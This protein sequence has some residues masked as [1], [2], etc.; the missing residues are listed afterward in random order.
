MT[1]LYDNVFVGLFGKRI[2]VKNATKTTYSEEDLNKLVMNFRNEFQSDQENR[3]YTPFRKEIPQSWMTRM[4]D[5]AFE[6]I[7]DDHLFTFKHLLEIPNPYGVSVQSALLLFNTSKEYRVRYR[8]LGKTEDCDF[9]GETPMTTRH[10]VPIFGLYKGYTNKLILELLDEQG[11]VQQRRDLR[12][13]TRDI[14]LNLQNIV[15]KVEKNE[16]FGFDFVMVNGLRFKPLVYDHNGEVRYSMQLRTGKF[17]M[18]PLENGHFLYED[19]T[20]RRVS[21]GLPF[22]CQYHEI[23]YLGRIYQSYLVDFPISTVLTQ[24]EDS[25]FLVTASGD[26]YKNDRIIEV[27][28]HSGKILS[29]CDMVDI[30]GEKYR[31]R[32]AWVTITGLC[33]VGDTLLITLRRFHTVLAVDWSSKE[34]QWVL[35]P[36][37]IW[38]D[39]PLEQKVLK[40]ADGQS[41]VDGYMP[42]S[43]HIQQ[44]K[45]GNICLSLYCIQDRGNVPAEGAE[46]SDD[47]RIVTYLVNPGKKQFEKKQDIDVVKAKRYASSSCEPEQNRILSFSGFLMRRSQNLRACIEELDGDTGQWINRLRLCKVYR[48]AWIFKPDIGAMSRKMGHDSDVLFGELQPPEVFEGTLPEAVEDR[49]RKK[50]FGNLRVRGDLF[51]CAFKPGSVQKVYLIGEQHSYVQDFSML[52][53]R[54]LKQ[55]FAISLKGLKRDE[56]QIY[57]E[58]GDQIYHLKNEIRVERSQNNK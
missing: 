17:G 8:V 7:L 9:V 30:L 5:M 21:G 24:K 58:Y 51:L 15:T 3:I 33:F 23:D 44:L 42:D 45:D 38:K 56:Y 40:A 2:D 11:Q 53:Q 35:A 49:L 19:T 22:S 37:S 26:K 29:S 20:A 12:I 46:G 57:V 27:D 28:R 34:V 18:V 50:I 16:P 14:P 1:H 31:N 48:G 25:L 39:T 47:S 6:K 52:P 55:S 43:S 4:R 13:Y 41:R 32:K 36:E 10:R 54:R